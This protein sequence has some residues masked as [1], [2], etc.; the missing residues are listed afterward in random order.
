MSDI[1]PPPPDPQDS[2]AFRE[3][4]YQV[5]MAINGQMSSF[6]LSMGTAGGLAARAAAE[7]QAASLLAK[8]AA[9]SQMRQVVEQQAGEL[10]QI[11]AQVGE[12]QKLAEQAAL[13]ASPQRD[14]PEPPQIRA[15]MLM[16]G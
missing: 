9:L 1:L 3:W 14:K 4:L 10:A 15:L 2:R 5:Y 11:R 6:V 16:G 13:M 8:D 7:A 12:L